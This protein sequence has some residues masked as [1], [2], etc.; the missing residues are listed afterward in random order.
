M[1]KDAIIS[2]QIL[3]KVAEGMDV[4]EAM[5]AVC[6]ADKVEAMISDLYDQLRAKA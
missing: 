3:T 6:G 2:A 4:I 1:P 5:K